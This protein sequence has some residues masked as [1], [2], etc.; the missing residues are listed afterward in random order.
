MSVYEALKSRIGSVEAKIIRQVALKAITL[1]WSVSVNDG[2]ETVVI[3]T[4]QLDTVLGEVGHTEETYFHFFLPDRTRL[5]FVWFVHGN[6][7]DVVTDH[8]DNEAINQLMEG[9]Y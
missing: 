4:L 9:V 6:G 7:E 1:G 5:G 2:E 8:S 3:P